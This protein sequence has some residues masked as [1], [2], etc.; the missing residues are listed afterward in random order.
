M[1][2]SVPSRATTSTNSIAP[3]GGA[4]PSL[5]PA[6]FALVAAAAFWGGNW[7]L[8]RWVQYAVPPQT[9]GALRWGCA[10]LILFPIVAPQL[11]RSWAGVKAEW[12]RLTFLGVLGVTGFSALSYTGLAYTTAINGSLLNTAAPVF[13]ILFAAFGLG[14][15]VGWF[16]IGGMIVSM[17]GVFAIV[18]RGTPEALMRLQFNIG[19]LWV[20]AAVLAWALYTV[21]IKRWRTKLPPLVFLFTTIAFS[22]PL[23]VGLS[24]F[25]LTAGGRS[26]TFDTTVALSVLYFG[27]FPSLGAYMFWNYGVGRVGPTRATLIQ[28][29]IP[30]FAAILAMLLLGESLRPFHIVGAALIIG[31]LVLATRRKAKA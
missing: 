4:T 9:L 24:L 13:L 21:L 12:K 10:A 1:S 15:R 6:Y 20:L 14:D 17:V 22:L 11:F 2:T 30:V 5:L 23:P 26:V 3:D 25:E 19:D 29:L 27:L 16:E 7:A 18:T 8:A 31:G 28:Y